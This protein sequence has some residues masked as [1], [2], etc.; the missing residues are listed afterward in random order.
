MIVCTFKMNGYNCFCIVNDWL[1][2][3]EHTQK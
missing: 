2:Y 1:E 3:V